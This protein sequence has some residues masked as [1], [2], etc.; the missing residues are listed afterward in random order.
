VSSARRQHDSMESISVKARECGSRP[1]RGRARPDYAVAVPSLRLDVEDSSS[2]AGFLAGRVST[3]I[4]A[5]L[6]NKTTTVRGVG[7]QVDDRLL[8]RDVRAS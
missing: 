7:D 6:H 1:I 3:L 8:V 4:E 5:R 2:L